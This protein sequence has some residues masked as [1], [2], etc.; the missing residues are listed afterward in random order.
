MDASV[1]LRIHALPAGLRE[2]LE[3]AEMLVHDLARGVVEGT[4]SP[5]Q[6]EEAR[7]LFGQILEYARAYLRDE[8]ERELFAFPRTTRP[9][10]PAA[11]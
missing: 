9:A 10:V 4:A 5:R 6:L 3:M 7:D 2:P 8:V 11:H 1:R